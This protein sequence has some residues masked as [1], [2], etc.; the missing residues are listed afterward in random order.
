MILRNEDRIKM[1]VDKFSEKGLDLN[2]IIDNNS[3]EVKGVKLEA[4]KGLNSNMS[5]IDIL[6]M[7]KEQN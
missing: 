5:N 2:D 3:K 4:E 1:Y 7:L 6:N